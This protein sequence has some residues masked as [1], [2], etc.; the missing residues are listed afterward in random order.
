MVHPPPNLKMKPICVLHV[1]KIGHSAGDVK[2]FNEDTWTKTVETCQ[3][4]KASPSPSTSKYTSISLPEHYSAD[5]GY[6]Y[7][8]YRKYTKIH[9]TVKP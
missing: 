4:R 2:P 6:H 7:E 1:E 5:I 3:Q 8:C 9:K